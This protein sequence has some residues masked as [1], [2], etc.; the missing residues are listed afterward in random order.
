MSMR[1]GAFPG[2]ARCAVARL[3]FYASYGIGVR[4]KPKRSIV[5]HFTFCKIASCYIQPKGSSPAKPPITNI[6]LIAAAARSGKQENADSNHRKKIGRF[7]RSDPEHVRQRKM[8][9]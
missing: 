3:R 5:R 8:C 1:P 2:Q 6:F 7:E 4:R 9:R